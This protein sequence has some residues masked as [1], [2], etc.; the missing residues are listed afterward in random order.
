[1]MLPQIEAYR[2]SVV[3]QYSSVD[4]DISRNSNSPHASLHVPLF[5]QGEL[6]F[7]VLIILHFRI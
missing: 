3:Q 6:V 7:D 1:M 4:A 2:Q 5:V